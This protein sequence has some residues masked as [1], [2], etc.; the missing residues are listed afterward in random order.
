MPD[1]AQDLIAERLRLLQVRDELL[2]LRAEEAEYRLGYHLLKR[3]HAALS[4]LHHEQTELLREN[5]TRAFVAEQR[6]LDLEAKL[7]A[8]ELAYTN[9]ISAIERSRSLR[10]G[11][12]LLSPFRW[13]R[14]AIEP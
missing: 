1:N 5:M 9:T 11:R 3:D 2:G 8:Q 13:A 14:R 12:A 6:V 7:A 4:S 10:L